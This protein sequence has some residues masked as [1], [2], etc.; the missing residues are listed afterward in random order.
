MAGKAGGRSER[1]RQ[2]AAERAKGNSKGGAKGNTPTVNLNQVNTW[3]SRY[4]DA[5]NKG[6]AGQDLSKAKTPQPMPSVPAAPAETPGTVPDAYIHIVHIERRPFGT[7]IATLP[8]VEITASVDD[9]DEDE[10]G[11]YGWGVDRSESGGNSYGNGSD[12]ERA[13]RDVN[14]NV[15]EYGDNPALQMVYNPKT[16]EYTL[17]N[18][19]TGEAVAGMRLN[20][21]DEYESYGAWEQM[22]KGNPDSLALDETFNFYEKNPDGTLNFNKVTKSMTT[23]KGVEKGYD[24]TTTTTEDEIYGKFTEKAH[25]GLSTKRRAPLINLISHL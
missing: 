12:S 9:K 6:S 3:G 4:D 25:A 1:S 13:N 8:A 5:A 10:Y 2:R 22:E 17:V 11:E 18:A 21:N 24:Y 23:K 20:D 16:H 14:S 19:A 7:D 15:M